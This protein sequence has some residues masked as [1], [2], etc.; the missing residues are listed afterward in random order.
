MTEGQ[1]LKKF[2][3]RLTA[4]RK[5][6]GITQE[7]LAEMID[8]HRTYIGFIEQG[9]RNPSIGNVYLIAKALKIDVKDLL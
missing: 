2:G 9:K 1:F 6:K 4:V 8:V 3:Q 7:R 5:Q